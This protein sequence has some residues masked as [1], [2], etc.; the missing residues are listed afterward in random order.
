MSSH[1]AETLRVVAG[2]GAAIIADIVPEIRQKL[3]DLDIPLAVDSPNA[4]RFRFFDAITS[5]LKR[6][7]QAAPLVLVLDD[8]QW[9]DESHL[10]LLE[11]L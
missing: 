9:A 8:L 5:F 3:P 6:A 10:R 4:E 11:F 7:A 2:S 1:D